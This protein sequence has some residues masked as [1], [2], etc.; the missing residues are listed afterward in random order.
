MKK[1]ARAAFVAFASTAAAMT[2]GAL[3]AMAQ[4]SQTS[5]QPDAADQFK[6]AGQHIGAAA[7][8]IGQ[9]IKEGAT[10]AW[11]ATKAGA[12]AVANKLN[13]QPAAPT[14]PSPPAAGDASH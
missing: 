13:G 12:S 10:Q 9:G 3:P 1:L 8:G 6:S 4:S 7:Q 5:A 14:A 2:A 11:D